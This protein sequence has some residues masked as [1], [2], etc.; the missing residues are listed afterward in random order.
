MSTLFMSGVIKY[1]HF[2]KLFISNSDV[3]VKLLSK[4]R[5][6]VKDHCGG[7]SDGL[8]CAAEPSQQ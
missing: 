7:R 4:W 5:L 1:F 3:D 6:E 2:Y 8:G